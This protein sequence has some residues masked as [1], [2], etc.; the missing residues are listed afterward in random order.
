MANS[1]IQVKR[2]NNKMRL[3]DCEL[4][5]PSVYVGIDAEPK[6]GIEY[7]LKDY[8]DASKSFCEIIF[9]RKRSIPKRKSL[10]GLL[11]VDISSKMSPQIMGRT[12]TVSRED[13]EISEEQII[14]KLVEKYWSFNIPSR[15]KISFEAKIMS[16]KKAPPPV[17]QD[18]EE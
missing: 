5:A 8:F 12:E 14:S 1:T 7:M 2:F 10:F 6:I 4:S 15:K 3:N 13:I 17:F 16:F 11:D 9:P 18:E